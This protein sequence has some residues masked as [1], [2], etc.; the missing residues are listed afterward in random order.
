MAITHASTIENLYANAEG[1]IKAVQFSWLFT[2]DSKP[3]VESRHG[4]T[5]SIEAAGLT[6]HAAEISINAAIE[7]AM[8]YAMPNLVAFQAN[9]L[10]FLYDVKNSTEILVRPAVESDVIAERLRRLAVG[11]SFDFGDAR[12]VHHIAT[13]PED[14]Q[15]WDEV[16]K[17]AAAYIASG[18]PDAPIAIKTDTGVASVTAMEWQ[19]VLIAAGDFRQP[20]FAASFALQAMTPIPSDYAS[21]AYWPA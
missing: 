15:N 6:I 8:Q 9:Q 17:L 2:D 20:I 18:T 5:V 14:L 13:T 12:G 16:T 21:A 1:M 7:T 3:G 10:A 4:G 19:R 11:F